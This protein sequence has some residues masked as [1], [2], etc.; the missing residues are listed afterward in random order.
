MMQLVQITAQY[1]NAVLVAILPHIS[2]FA[3]KLDLPIPAP[4][5]TAQVLDFKCDPR[6]EETGGFV[7]LTNGFRF[8]FMDGRVCVYRSPQSY[9][10]L[11]DPDLIPKT[12]GPIKVKQKEALRIARGVIQKL[13]YTEEM[14]FADTA[15]RITPPEKIGTNYVARYRF[16]WQ[17]PSSR[18]GKAGGILVP[19]LLDVE[20][21][22]S[23]RQ[24]QMVSI[25]SPATRRPSP[26]VAISPPLLH[27]S[28][29]AKKQYSGG[30]QTAPVNPAY[31][32]LFLEAILPQL[33]DFAARI[34]LPISLPLTT[35]QVDL[36]QYH[37][38]VLQGQPMAQLFLKNGDRFNYQHGHVTDFYAHDAYRKFPEYGK[39]E[40]F[41]GRINMKTNEA[42]RM[43]ERVIKNLGYKETL[44][45]PFFG[46]STYVGRNELS[47]YIFYWGELNH[48]FAS[49]E[50]D[51]ETKAIKSVYLDHPSL[52]RDPP[53]IDVPMMA[54]TNAPPPASRK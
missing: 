11:Q 42:I 36:S 1:S 19:V 7:S 54:E 41:L 37:C 35:N 6:Q 5:T 15:P 2:D 46:G 12:Y 51:M 14:F 21:D 47:R 3:Q 43:C 49:F 23:T 53:E 44:P 22:A 28:P 52:R 31:A 18:L 13:G 17:D 30:I 4:V 29:P 40:D 38:R 34:G 25:S 50:V 48:E 27:E 8:T 33:S 20:V 39:L 24:V 32:A 26:K 9:F 45:K 16:R 10:S